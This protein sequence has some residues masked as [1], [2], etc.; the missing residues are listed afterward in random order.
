MLRTTSVG[1]LAL[2]LVTLVNLQAQAQFPPVITEIL[3]NGE[4][5]QF[6]ILP[7][8]AQTPPVLVGRAK[9]IPQPVGLSRLIYPGANP[10]PVRAKFN[11]YIVQQ[12]GA[13]FDDW[14]LEA[15]PAMPYAS[16]QVGRAVARLMPDGFFYWT[17]PGLA[18]VL[19]P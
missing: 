9:L 11:R 6:Q 18:P 2:V 14:Y 13:V 4:V 17:Y 5:I 12:N 7:N 19:T 8:G 15:N 16:L 1:I 3:P 10:L